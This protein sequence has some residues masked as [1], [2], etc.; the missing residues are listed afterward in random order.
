MKIQIFHHAKNT[1]SQKKIL[2]MKPK[3]FKISI[4]TLYN[5]HTRKTK[6]KAKE[7]PKEAQLAPS[8]NSTT[9]LKFEHKS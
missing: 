5:H 1:M 9:N 2:E 6:G 4:I 8:P 3:S 7:R